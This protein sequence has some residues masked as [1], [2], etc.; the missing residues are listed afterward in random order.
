ME[1]KCGQ[2]HESAQVPGQCV[3]LGRPWPWLPF[4]EEHK[5]PKIGH[6]GME[7]RMLDK[8]ILSVVWIPQ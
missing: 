7:R 3:S 6:T 5:L 8:M 1:A 4:L 2:S